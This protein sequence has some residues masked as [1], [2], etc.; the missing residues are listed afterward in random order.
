MG[1]VTADISVSLDGYLAGPD[2]TQ[3]EPLGKG[4]EG[5][6]EWVIATKGWR[7]RHGYEGGETGVDS[8]MSER[9]SANMGAVVMGRAM[10][11]PVEGGA[12]GD[13]P[14]DGWWGDDPPFHVPVYVLTHYE[15]EPLEKDGGTTF[16]FVTGGIES[17]LAQARAAAGDAEVLVAGGGDVIRQSIH[18]GAVDELQLHIVPILLGAGT[19]L[20]DGLAPSSVE[21]IEVVDSPAVTHIR[22]RMKP[23]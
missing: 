23:S 14:W 13:E 17:A 15:R 19:R 10:F 7:E 2:P 4:G 3:D 6:H 21:L 9:A 5:L 18:A 1:K 8:E 16:H 11:G 20:F 22:Y 12:W